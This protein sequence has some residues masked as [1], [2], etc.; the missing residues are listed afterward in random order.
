MDSG[1]GTVSQW[2][3]GRYLGMPPAHACMQSP[4][5]EL[6]GSRLP[7]RTCPRP[8]LLPGDTGRGPADSSVAA[9]PQHDKVAQLVSRHYLLHAHSRPLCHAEPQRSIS[10]PTPRLGCGTRVRPAGLPERRR[11][12]A[13]MARP[14][15][16]IPQARGARS[17]T[18]AAARWTARGARL[19]AT[20]APWREERE[21]FACWRG[22]GAPAG[23]KGRAKSLLR[24]RVGCRRGAAPPR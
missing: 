6:R 20:R 16:C 1:R 22:A 15:N 5:A 21:P 2:V 12:S 19:H 23:R 14:A 10:R 17:G 13:S 4:M 9:L 8:V 24:P 18:T 3:S 7:P 11:T